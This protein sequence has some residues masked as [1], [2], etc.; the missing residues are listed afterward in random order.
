M[1][2]S[3]MEKMIREL[4]EQ[5][6]QPGPAESTLILTRSTAEMI[7]VAKYADERLGRAEYFARSCYEGDKRYV[8]RLSFVVPEAEEPADLWVANLHEATPDT[9]SY[10]R[11]SADLTNHVAWP[12]ENGLYGVVP[13]AL[14]RDIW[15]PGYAETGFERDRSYPDPYFRP[16]DVSPD[17]MYSVGNP[18]GWTPPGRKVSVWEHLRRNLSISMNERKEVN[19][20]PAKKKAAK[21]KAKVK[22]TK[23]AN[24]T[25][26]KSS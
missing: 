14:W 17:L 24:K 12:D 7:A 25:A 4:I 13:Y 19:A 3:K 9:L 8:M 6:R 26:K 16:A 18:L 2:N 15:H 23:K 1:I 5:L 22:T 20:M 21:A 11:D 10:F